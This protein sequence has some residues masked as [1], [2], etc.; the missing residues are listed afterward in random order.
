MHYRLSLPEPHSHLFHVEVVLERPGDTLEL[1][2]PV[3]TPGS[4]LV[5]EFARHLEGAAAED[6]AGRGFRSSGSTS[7]ASSS[8]RGAPSAPSSATA[9]TRTS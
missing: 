8:G 9:S 3:W 7:T 1:V 2:F 6:G 4:Y 5:R